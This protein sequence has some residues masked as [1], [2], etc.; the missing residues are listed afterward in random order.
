MR[1]LSYQAVLMPF[2]LFMGLPAQAATWVIDPADSHV[3]FK[4]SYSETP[5]EGEFKNVEA[6]FEIDL[7]SPGDCK[8]SITLPIADISVDDPETLDYLLDLE[9]FD[10]DQW[11]T[12]S[13]KA[14][15]CRL[16]SL[17]TFVSDGNLTIRDQTHPLSFPFKLKVDTSGGKIRFHLTSEVTIKRLEYGVG[18]G[19]WAGTAEIPNDVVIA[20]DVYAIK[21]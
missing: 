7:L 18:Q 11:P 6:T 5:Y 16:E 8:F 14:E 9:M 13:F 12:A 1:N 2:L 19:Y 15:K 20:V 3:I 17:D 4:Y 21:Q 10:V